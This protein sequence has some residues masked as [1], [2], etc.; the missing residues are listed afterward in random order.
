MGLR[1]LAD[2]LVVVHLSFIVFVVAGGLAVLRWPRTAWLHLPA[3]AW[4][5]FA[6]ATATTCPLTPIENAL[7]RQAGDAG[8]PG[9]FVEHYLVPVVYPAGL[10]PRGQLALAFAVA[11]INLAV[12]ALILHRRHHHRRADPPRGGYHSRSN[13]RT[14]EAGAMQSFEQFRADR[15]AAGFDEVVERRWAPGT[16]V[17]T[18]THPFEADGLVA[19]GEMWLAV[20]GGPE[21]R[22]QPGERFHLARD[23]PHAERYGAEGATYW[24]ARRG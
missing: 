20:A 12:Y 4:G 13:A 5:I 14:R 3:V 16:V 15:I 22:L 17:A 19:E 18:H 9:G 11:A 6:E 2:A 24:V 8:Y 1:F 10:T 23:V 21:R 7:R